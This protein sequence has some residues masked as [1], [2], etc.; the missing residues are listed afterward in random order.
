MGSRGEERAD[1][2]QAALQALQGDSTVEWVAV[3]DAARPH[4]DQIW[5]SLQ[6]FLRLTQRYWLGL[7]L[8][9]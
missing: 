4:N 2:V 6:R 8:A 9:P 3:H 1:S 5:I 7:S